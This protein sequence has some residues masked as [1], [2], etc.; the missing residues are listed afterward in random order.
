M[1]RQYLLDAANYPCT[2]VVAARLHLEGHSAEEFKNLCKFPRF[3]DVPADTQKSVLSHLH[4]FENGYKIDRRLKWLAK[5]LEW[6]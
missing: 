1:L 5:S 2:L 6:P 4:E 3:R